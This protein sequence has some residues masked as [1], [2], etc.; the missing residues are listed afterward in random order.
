[1]DLISFAFGAL[2]IL[3][4]ISVIVLIVTVV[5]VFKLFSEL[6]IERSNR[7]SLDV[8][9]HASIEACYRDIPQECKSYTDS[10]I[11]KLNK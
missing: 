4:M 11:D 3:A 5:K 8:N 9:I 2:A 6:E 7:E 10:R 1:M